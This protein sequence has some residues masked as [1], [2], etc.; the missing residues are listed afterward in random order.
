MKPTYLQPNSNLVFLEEDVLL[1]AWEILKMLLVQGK[2]PLTV[3]LLRARIHLPRIILWYIITWHIQK[4]E[5][6]I[7]QGKQPLGR[8]NALAKKLF[9]PFW[10]CKTARGMWIHLVVWFNMIFLTNI[11]SN[12]W[13][14]LFGLT[15]VTVIEQPNDVCTWNTKKHFYWC[16]IYLYTQHFQNLLF[17][18]FPQASSIW[19]LPI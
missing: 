14:E 5:K 8:C 11:Q 17:K 18:S 9:H 10:E 16:E 15:V 3:Y 4:K 2:W 6:A 19:V 13:S 7:A 12:P 1:R